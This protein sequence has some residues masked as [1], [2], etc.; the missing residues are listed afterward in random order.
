MQM[1]TLQMCLWNADKVEKSLQNQQLKQQGP[2]LFTPT[3]GISVGASIKGKV[4]TTPRELPTG[5]SFKKEFNVKQEI[6]TDKPR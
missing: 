3:R 1:P 5:D 2:K 4:W 6:H